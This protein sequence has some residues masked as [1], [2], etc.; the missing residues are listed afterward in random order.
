MKTHLV[1]VTAATLLFSVAPQASMIQLF[2][3][4]DCTDYDR[5]NIRSLITT[6]IDL[7][8]STHADQLPSIEPYQENGYSFGASLQLTS[9][10]DY[11]LLSSR[12][13]A[14]F[15]YTRL[16]FI[17]NETISAV[18]IP[19]EWAYVITIPRTPINLGESL[20]L[21]A[22]TPPTHVPDPAA[23]AAL[24]SLSLLPL[25]FARINKNNHPPSSQK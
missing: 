22:P 16:W 15:C 6:Q 1:L 5:N 10:S 20:Q 18:S 17:S 3:D 2:E 11:Y 7:Y 14:R 19:D 23:T 8:N 12:E 9:S 4:L 21:G 24:L 13:D 25:A